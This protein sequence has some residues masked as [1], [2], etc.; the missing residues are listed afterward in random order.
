MRTRWRR[1]C[2]SLVR[3]CQSP[4]R[5]RELQRGACPAG[6]LWHRYSQHARLKLRRIV[7]DILDLD[8][9]LRVAIHWRLPTGSLN[10]EQNLRLGLMIQRMGNPY[11]AR[12]G[13]NAEVTI[14]I[15]ISNPIPISFPPL[16]SSAYVSISWFY[17]SCNSLQVLC[18]HW[19]GI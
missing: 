6:I 17:C 13:L 1:D 4:C 18:S 10:V 16:F 19:P 3:C 14:R 12:G 9:N 7:I 5:G 2:R 15:P 8:V 11:I